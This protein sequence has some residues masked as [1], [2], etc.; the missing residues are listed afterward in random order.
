MKINNTTML[1][2]A[3]IGLLGAT[4]SPAAMAAP[5]LPLPQLVPIP[6]EQVFAPPGFDDND[7]VQIVIHGELINTCY[8]AAHAHVTVDRDK[9]LITVV[10]QAYVYDGEWCLSVLVPFTD[11]VDLGILPAGQYHV[12]EY[13]QG[14]MVHDV[15]L[16]IAQ[17]KTASPDDYLYAPVKNAI[18][19]TGASG[20]ELVLS[21]TFASDCMELQDVKVLYRTPHIIEVL[22]IAS[23]KTGTTCDQNPR[24]FETDV[25][26]PAVDP[27]ETLIYVRSLNGQAINVVEML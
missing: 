6:S 18:L 4:V 19:K 7:N 11:T 3:F 25:K 14:R 17:A 5:G 22:P 26:L 15:I 1:A 13:T 16:P 2:T 21:G 8:K 12:V 20:Q 10:P 27:G 23:Y 24:P 9:K